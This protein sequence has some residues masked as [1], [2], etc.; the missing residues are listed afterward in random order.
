MDSIAASIT[1]SLWIYFET[2]YKP[3]HSVKSLLLSLIL[4][5]AK[6]LTTHL[7]SLISQQRTKKIVSGLTKTYNV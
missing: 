7:Y 3:L 1:P 6:N 5:A 2:I 4:P